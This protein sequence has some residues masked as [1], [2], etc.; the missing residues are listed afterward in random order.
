MKKMCFIVLLFFVLAACK[1]QNKYRYAQVFVPEKEQFY[2]VDTIQIKDPTIIRFSGVDFIMEDSLVNRKNIM[3]SFDDTNYYVFG[4][5][6]IY[7][8]LGIKILTV[9]NEIFRICKEHLYDMIGKSKD[10]YLLKLYPKP[11]YF[12][13]ALINVEYYNR[14]HSSLKCHLDTDLPNSYVR[15]VYPAYEDSLHYRQVHY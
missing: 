11:N 6:S 3:K 7:Y 2:I 10:Y 14:R 15:I 8:D 9:N 4:E 13:L 1:S 12:V 5:G